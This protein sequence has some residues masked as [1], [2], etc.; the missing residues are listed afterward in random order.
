[1]TAGRLFKH[2]RLSREIFYLLKKKLD[3]FEDKF[4][5]NI[6]MSDQIRWDRDFDLD[7]EQSFRHIPPGQSANQYRHLI[8]H[9]PPTVVKIVS[10]AQQSSKMPPIL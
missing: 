1:M 3:H 10:D 5:K 9:L 4:K 8:C 6:Q 7:L 2:N